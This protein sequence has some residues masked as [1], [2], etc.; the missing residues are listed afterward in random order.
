MKEFWQVAAAKI[1]GCP[2]ELIEYARLDINIR[3]FLAEKQL[4]RNYSY[5]Q[6]EQEDVQ[7]KRERED[8]ADWNQLKAFQHYLRQCYPAIVQ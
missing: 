3:N 5:T 2:G 4:R 6:Q 7:L 1:Q 8:F